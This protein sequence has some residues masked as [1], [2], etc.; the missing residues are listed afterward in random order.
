MAKA[1]Y[2]GEW[3]TMPNGTRIF[4]KDG[5]SLEEAFIRVNASNKRYNSLNVVKQIEE[6]KVNSINIQ[7]KVVGKNNFMLQS[8]YLQLTERVKQKYKEDTQLRQQIEDLE[9]QLKNETYLKPKSEWDLNDDIMNLLGDT[10][11]AYTEKGKQLSEQ[12]K[13]LQKQEDT[14]EA[15]WSRLTDKLNEI[16]DQYVKQNLQSWKKSI[17]TSKITQATKNDYFGFETSRTTVNSVD[18]MLKNGQAFVVQM[19]PKSY[20]EQA[21]YNIFGNSIENI[22]SGRA[23]DPEAISDFMLMMRQGIKFHTPYL[24]Y[25]SG[26]QEGL[27]RAIAAY[28]LGLNEMPVV[29]IPKR[30]RKL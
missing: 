16:N 9:L 22:V 10:P 23:A 1:Y 15:E 11:V 7:E 26:N 14:V 24:N 4:I 25:E 2:G 20:I 29:I 6:D 28:L 27:H 5:E 18:T 19:P 17:D 8:N 30:G 3:K 21:A 12:L 13:I